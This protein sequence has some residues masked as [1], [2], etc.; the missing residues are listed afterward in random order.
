M[1]SNVKKKKKIKLN[2]LELIICPILILYAI[3]LFFPLGWSF[4]TTFKHRFDFE[5]S[6]YF[7]LPNF[8]IWERFKLPFYDNYRILLTLFESPYGVSYFKGF[9]NIAVTEQDTPNLWVVL[10]NTVS[11]TIGTTIVFAFTSAL[12]AYLCAKYRYKF[13]GIVCFIVIFSITT[14]IVGAQPATLK[15]LKQLGLFNRVYGQYIHQASFLSM[16][17]LILYAF[18][19]GLSNTYNEAAEIDGA[20]QFRTMVSICMPMA[21]NMIT[22]IC[23][24]IFVQRWNDYN[25]PLLYMPT[26]VTL[27]FV[28]WYNIA[29][30]TSSPIQEWPKKFSALMVLAIPILL[31]FIFLKK[32]LMGN[33]SL[34]GIKE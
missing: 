8:D 4:M 5:N 20:S 14:P 29:Q 1:I 12:V 26:K 18:F 32:R 24:L 34:G 31:L 21:L 22:T 33:I 10:Y 25:T 19:E 2:A 7:D 11:Y 9:N 3:S 30:N 16:Y 15:I 27:A 13:S 6:G 17:F 23:L 28:V